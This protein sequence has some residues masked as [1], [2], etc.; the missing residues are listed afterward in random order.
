M[1]LTVR[2]LKRI[3]KEAVN[4]AHDDMV[5]GPINPI[6]DRG[7]I[8]HKPKSKPRSKPPSKPSSRE[9]QIARFIGELHFQ[10]G[11]TFGDEGGEMPW[12]EV[13]D[14]AR[15]KGVKT[16]PAEL[17]KVFLNSPL[18]DDSLGWIMH[19]TPSGFFFDNPMAL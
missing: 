17:E 12:D 6:D 10:F 14:F 11:H 7:Q 18:V 4:E 13:M 19:V 3:I 1:R 15:E 5:P 2:H 8:H 16:T 9:A